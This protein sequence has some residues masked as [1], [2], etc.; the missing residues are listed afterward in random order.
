MN[1]KAKIS[2]ITNK[3]GVDKGKVLQLMNQKTGGTT[4]TM[5]TNIQSGLEIVNKLI[6]H[7]GRTSVT[8]APSIFTNPFWYSLTAS[9][10]RD[11]KWELK[12]MEAIWF[13]NMIPQMQWMGA[14]SNSEGSRLAAAYSKLAD[15]WIPEANYLEEL[16]RLKEWMEK[17]L[18][19]M[20]ATI[21]EEPKQTTGWWQ[22]VGGELDYSKYE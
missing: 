22:T 10:A 12:R 16:N 13:L 21:P 6:N 15:T 17:A 8:G 14:L 1:G 11:F 2:D 7:P 5:Q 19:N 9:D 3:D 18:K 4:G 20:W